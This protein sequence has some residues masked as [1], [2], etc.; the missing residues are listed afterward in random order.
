MNDSCSWIDQKHCCTCKMG[1]RKYRFH[2]FRK[3]RSKSPTPEIATR[4]SSRLPRFVFQFA[5]AAADH[6]L[7]KA[8]VTTVARRYFPSAK[9]RGPVFTWQ[10]AFAWQKIEETPRPSAYNFDIQKVSRKTNSNSLYD[11]VKAPLRSSDYYHNH[12]LNSVEGTIV[13]FTQYQLIAK[14]FELMISI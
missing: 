7:R 10:F 6:F 12:P 1:K 2:P 11:R 5:R 4:Y 8:G 9:R 14:I 3:Q 13:L